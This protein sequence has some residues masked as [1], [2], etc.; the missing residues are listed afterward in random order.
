[1]SFRCDGKQCK[2][3]THLPLIF[4]ARYCWYQ[5][6]G[7]VVRRWRWGGKRSEGGRCLQMSLAIR[8][9]NNGPIMDGRGPGVDGRRKRRWRREDGDCGAS[10][11]S[12]WFRWWCFEGCDPRQL[13]H[14][15]YWLL[16]IL[17]V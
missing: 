3:N 16:I 14:C 11:C 2:Q 4:R 1:V 7:G 8:R 15:R 17:Q 5:P 6:G 10:D 12:S 9:G 13:D